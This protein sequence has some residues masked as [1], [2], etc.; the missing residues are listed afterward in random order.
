M[1]K[2]SS[3]TIFLN[4]QNALIM[5]ELNMRFS[6]GRMG[7]FWTFFEPFFQIIIFVF[8]KIVIFPRS[9]SSFDF[10]VFLALN[11]IAFNMFKNIVLKSVSAFHANRALFVYKQVKPIDTIIA[12]TVIEVFIT[13]IIIGMFLIVGYY[14]EFDLDSPN[15][16]MVTSGFLFLLS[17]SFSFAIFIAILNIYSESVS[18]V[19][20]FLMTA[21]MF[22]SAVIYSIEML[23]V[24][25]QNL[26]LYNPL[27][28]F[29]EMIHGY[30]FIALDDQFVDYNYMLLWTLILLFIGL[31]SYLK[32]EK[33]IIS[34]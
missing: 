34:S 29:M 24:E 28:H 19:I 11:F 9:G 33:R 26:L 20:S 15:L 22:A 18:K 31:W 25:L 6:S 4:V 8:I 10:A 1:T 27:T 3:L 2:R 30:Y 21:L 17:F 5:R 32:L 13:L 16:P 7:L 12:R 14:F 23:P